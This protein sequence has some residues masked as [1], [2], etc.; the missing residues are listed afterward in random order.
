MYII[1]KMYFII[2]NFIILHCIIL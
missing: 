2:F 1:I